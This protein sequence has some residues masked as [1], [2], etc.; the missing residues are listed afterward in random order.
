MELPS[1]VVDDPRGVLGSVSAWVYGEPAA[2]LAT[3]GI[4]GTN[5]KTTVSYL[6]DAAL[7]AGGHTTGVIGTVAI[8]PR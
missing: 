1:C 8:A 4:T 2:V 7:R 3:T 6:L 5:G